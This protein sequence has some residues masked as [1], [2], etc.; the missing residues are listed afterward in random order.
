MRVLRLEW[1]TFGLFIGSRRHVAGWQLGTVYRGAD[2][3]TRVWVSYPATEKEN[4]IAALMLD[5]EVDGSVALGDIRRG[6]R[7]EQRI[8]AE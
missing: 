8:A 5:P 3:E 6:G 2:A 7:A 1:K 4:R